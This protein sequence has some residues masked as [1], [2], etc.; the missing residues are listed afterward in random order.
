MGMLHPIKKSFVSSLVKLVRQTT[1]AD[2]T[3]EG[4]D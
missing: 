3:K 2:K 1:K 4:E